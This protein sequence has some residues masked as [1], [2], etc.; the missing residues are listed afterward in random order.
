MRPQGYILVIFTSF[1]NLF[2]D[3]VK[4]NICSERKYMTDGTICY[5]IT[6]GQ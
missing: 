4:I 3:I 2:L 5:K 6:P 1:V